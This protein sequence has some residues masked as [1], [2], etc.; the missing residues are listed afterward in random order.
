MVDY[1]TEHIEAVHQ[2]ISVKYVLS[3]QDGEKIKQGKVKNILDE[4]QSHQHGGVQA[5]FDNGD[6][7]YIKEIN[8]THKSFSYIQDLIKKG[9]TKNLEFKASFY[10]DVKKE[11]GNQCL[12]D[13]IPRAVAAFMN[14]DGGELLIGVKNNGTVIGLDNDYS[15]YNQ[16]TEKPIDD[17]FKLD[18][19]NYI[20]ERLLD[21]FEHF[22]D[23][24]I[25]PYE[26]YHIAIIF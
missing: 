20:K 10:Y 26:K 16:N 24:E 8:T 17:H 13:E 23:I 12:K 25:Y 6:I 15:S 14:T 18:I 1:N 22:Y 21:N 11:K 19:R 2:G 5:R 4:T 9:E 7:G 3:L